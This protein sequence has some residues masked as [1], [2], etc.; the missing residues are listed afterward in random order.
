MRHPKA[1]LT[2]YWCVAKRLERGTFSWPADIE[3]GRE[4]LILKPTALAMLT[5]GIDMRDGMRRSAATAM[6]P[7]PISN[8]STASSC[9]IP[10]RTK[11]RPCCRP[12]GSPQSKPSI[13]YLQ[14][15]V[16]R[17]QI[18]QDLWH[19]C[20][21]CSVG[22]LRWD[23]QGNRILIGKGTMT[24]MDDSTRISHERTA[25]PADHRAT[26]WKPQKQKCP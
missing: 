17:C 19:K 12:P 7:T 10:A 1:V 4:K 13:R 2:P 21:S 11:C 15:R 6:I 26:G 25:K 24:D 22:R 5:D 16:H 3:E 20:E 18:R 8:G 9:M 23:E 14:R